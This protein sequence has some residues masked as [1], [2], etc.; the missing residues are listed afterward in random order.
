MS[1]GSLC[2]GL[3][4]TVN[5]AWYL[6]TLCCPLL[7]PLCHWQRPLGTLVAVCTPPIRCA[8]RGTTL[9]GQ[10][11]RFCRCH[12]LHLCQGSCL[13]AGIRICA[14]TLWWIDGR[15]AVLGQVHKHLRVE[16]GDRERPKESGRA[17]TRERVGR[18]TRN[19][20]TGW[21]DVWTKRE[22]RF[23]RHD[24]RNNRSEG[25]MRD[26]L[27]GI[28]MAAERK[29]RWGSKVHEKE[30]IS[31][32]TGGRTEVN[33]SE[34]AGKRRKGFFI[35]FFYLFSAAHFHSVLGS[36]PVWHSQQ[37]SA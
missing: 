2:T 17:R 32:S 35:L 24:V 5:R 25:E 30:H 14:V 10:H 16:E 9:L 37:D 3:Y 29:R 28:K 33:G 21:L 20:L 6:W 27:G 31:R 13:V 12:C 1:V 18:Q 26:E 23:G 34:W 4:W 8:G 15:C 11:S 19:R 7:S 22:N 36:Q